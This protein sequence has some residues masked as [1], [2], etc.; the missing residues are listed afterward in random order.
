[1]ENKKPEQKQ[2]D[3][4]ELARIRL[5]CFETIANLRLSPDVEE[6]ERK[7]EH[8]YSWILRGINK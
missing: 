5:K 8:V 6:L 7:A 1:M 3:T 4:L 2:N